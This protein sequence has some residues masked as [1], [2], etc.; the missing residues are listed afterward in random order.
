MSQSRVA[1]VLASAREKLEAAGIDNPHI[2][3]RLLLQHASDLTHSQIIAEPDQ[4]LDAS[5]VA[6]FDAALA[7]R[8]ARE[9]VSKIVGSR[10]FWSLEFIVSHDV[11]DP[12]PDS[13][14]L[15]EA[16]LDEIDDRGATLRILDL[17]TG[18]GC[19]LITL[20][21][22][23]EQAQG[24][25]LDASASALAIARQ[26]A[27][28][29]AVADRITFMEGDWA[30]AVGGERFDIVVSNPPYIPTEDI[31]DL[32]PEVR[33]FDPVIALDGGADGLDSYRRIIDLLPDLLAPEGLV[34]FE[35]GDNQSE[36]VF[37]ILEKAGAVN[38][39][40]KSDLAG[41]KRC[42]FGHF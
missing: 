12:R 37:R 7:R 21:N 24:V 17:G 26:N 1:D 14:T 19:L 9:P 34:V 25:G 13:E 42:V 31:E 28:R 15:I 39:G 23:L 11:L 35:V 5:A 41:V 6:S 33:L 16:V 36:D 8:L 3:A 10:E 32:Q 20:L 40:A 30:A 27:E 29:L 18:G 2:D 38:I 4:E 22:E